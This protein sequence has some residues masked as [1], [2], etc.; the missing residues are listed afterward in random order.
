MGTYGAFWLVVVS[1][2]VGFF[3]G[4]WLM[5]DHIR[6]KVAGAPVEYLT[7]SDK[8]CSF[9]VELPDHTREWRWQPKLVT[10]SDTP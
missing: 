3:V 9:L 6:D 2:I 5:Y 7:C 4:N 1:A 10:K 8:G